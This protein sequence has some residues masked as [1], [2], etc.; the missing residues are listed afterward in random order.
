MPLQANETLV[1][2]SLILLV[3]SPFRGLFYSGESDG[4]GVWEVSPLRQEVMI[5]S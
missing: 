1:L 4:D 5:L 3:S 2:V